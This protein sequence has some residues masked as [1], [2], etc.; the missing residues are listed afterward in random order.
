[1]SAILQEAGDIRRGD[2]AGLFPAVFSGAAAWERRGSRGSA[3]VFSRKPPGGPGL[4]RRGGLR[5]ALVGG[6]H[7]RGTGAA[8]LCEDGVPAPVRAGGR[9]AAV[10]GAGGGAHRHRTGHSGGALRGGKTLGTGATTAS[11][12]CSPPC[13]TGPRRTASPCC[14]TAPT[15]PTTPGTGRGCGP[16]RNFPSAPPCGSAA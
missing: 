14:W 3:S 8:L 6:G 12:P 4:F 2:P 10:P 11:G 5:P 13:G 16:S 1:M 9:P 15:P 7:L